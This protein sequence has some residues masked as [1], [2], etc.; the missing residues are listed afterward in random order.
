MD[1][2][3]QLWLQVLRHLHLHAAV[4]ACTAAPTLATLMDPWPLLDTWPGT[5]VEGMLCGQDKAARED[6]CRWLVAV[7]HPVEDHMLWACACDA[8][9]IAAFSGDLALYTDAAAME[10]RLRPTRP[11]QRYSGSTLHRLA[12]TG[13]EVMKYALDSGC[14]A[15][16]LQVAATLAP[17][18]H[19]DMLAEA[20]S[21]GNLAVCQWLVDHHG[22]P[23]DGGDDKIFALQCAI[24]QGH[25]H[26]C[27][28]LVDRFG[29]TLQDARLHQSLWCLERAVASNHLQTCRW[30]MAHQP[31]DTGYCS[32]L[33]DAA[34]HG[35][36]GMCRWLAE[37]L[38][39][40]LHRDPAVAL[41]VILSALS[42][43]HYALATWLADQ[44]PHH[45]HDGKALWRVAR[46]GK[47]DACQFVVARFRGKVWCE[48]DT[49]RALLEAAQRGH[50]DVCRWLAARFSANR[51]TVQALQRA[52]RGG[53]K[54]VCVWLADHFGLTTEQVAANDNKA[55]TSAVDN[56]NLDVCRWL[57]ARF[58]LTPKL[59]LEFYQLEAYKHVH[60][61]RWLVAA[62]R[63]SAADARRALEKAVIV[64]NVA[65]CRLLAT[66]CDF[67]FASDAERV[68][69]VAWESL[70]RILRWQHSRV[71]RWLVSHFELTAAHRHLLPPDALTRIALQADTPTCR[72]LVDHFQLTRDMSRQGRL[73]ALRAAARLGG[74]D[75]CEWLVDHLGVTVEEVRAGDTAPFRKAAKRGNVQVCRWLVDRFGLTVD[76]VHAVHWCSSRDHGVRRWMALRFALTP[77]VVRD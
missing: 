7:A 19:P 63:P 68:C 12:L 67:A 5:T 3:P 53:H 29:V 38:T 27:H 54:A 46:M 66:R 45:A 59:P 40:L 22:V 15:V 73:A 24:A 55:L 43:G 23:A 4:R 1:L 61:C 8:V 14:L 26:V 34:Q 28:W 62:A 76:D 72:W 77:D 31:M 51:F 39:P 71:C 64:G 30:M 52:A 32:L 33:R 25:L 41:E 44:F 20:A 65:V 74:V 75:K 13:G 35:H 60:V 18:Y 57:V 17:D 9:R 37:R 49:S 58:G 21:C 2:P 11:P 48:N 42:H 16:C 36:D 6:A 10:R 70:C 47:V 56:A 50:L 69:R